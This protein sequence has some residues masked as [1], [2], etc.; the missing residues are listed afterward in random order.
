[1]KALLKWRHC[2]KNN[3][4]EA[5]LKRSFVSKQERLYNDFVMGA[6]MTDKAAVVYPHRRKMDG[7]H[8]SICLNCL[9]TI[10]MSLDETE[11]TDF[12]TSHICNTTFVAKRSASPQYSV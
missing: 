12:D 11:A 5:T 1:M 10:E 2:T 7:S 4:R 3:A 9:G 8:D 6:N